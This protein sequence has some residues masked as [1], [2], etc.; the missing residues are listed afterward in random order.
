MSVSGVE[1]VTRSSGKRHANRLSHE[2]LCSRGAGS[3]HILRND[4]Q[5]TFSSLSAHYLVFAIFLERFGGRKLGVR[6]SPP[7]QFP[8][9]PLVRRPALRGLHNVRGWRTPGRN[10]QVYFRRDDTESVK[11]RAADQSRATDRETL[12]ISFSFLPSR[13][14]S[15]FGF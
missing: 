14:T 9:R 2:T 10:L 8:P 4:N 6:Q 1:R 13:Y 5:F 15:L 3:K 11:P 7:F 12:R